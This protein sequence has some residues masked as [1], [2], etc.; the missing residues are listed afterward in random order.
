MTPRP[1]FA[2]IKSSQ[3]FSILSQLEMRKLRPG[4]VKCFPKI[5]QRGRQG[6]PKEPGW[7]SPAFC[8]HFPFASIWETPRYCQGVYTGFHPASLCQAASS[9]ATLVSSLPAATASSSEAFR[10]LPGC[11]SLK[12]QIWPQ[13]SSAESFHDPII[14]IKNILF[15]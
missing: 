10:S 5:T 15:T 6:W 9:I 13:H 12:I 8:N 7:R 3:G 1:S 11:I 4:Q 14:R 2:Y